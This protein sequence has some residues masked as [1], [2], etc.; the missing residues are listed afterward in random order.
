MRW[1]AGQQGFFRRRLKNWPCKEEDPS[2]AEQ[3]EARIPGV[4]PW[5]IEHC[6][7]NTEDVHQEGKGVGFY[8]LRRSLR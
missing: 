8:F 2:F 1:Y 3:G 7:G 6:Q 4:R 5:F